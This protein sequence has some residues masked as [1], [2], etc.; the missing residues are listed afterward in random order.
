M[1]DFSLG[2]DFGTSTTLVA[3][4]GLEPR[5]F[6]IGKEAG[7][8]WLPS[9][10][11]ID[12]S[13]NRLIGEDADRGSIQHQFRSPKSAITKS[14]NQITNARGLEVSADEIILEVL[15]EVRI[16]CQENG[17][18][19]FSSVRLSCPAMWTGDQRRRLIRLVNESGLISDIDNILDEP[20]AASVAWWWSRFSKGLKIQS[21]KRA[22]IFDL[23]GGT[24]DV[25]LVDFFPGRALPEMTILSARGIDIAGDELDKR[26]AEHLINRLADEYNFI[27]ED[28]H[29][30]RVLEVA[31]RLAARECKE[32]LSSVEETIF[33]VDPRIAKV[34]SLT[35]SRVELN[36]VFDPLMKSARDCVEAAL[37]EARLKAGNDASGTTVSKLPIS[38]LGEEIDFVVLAGG[39]SQIPKVA[40]DLQLMMPNAQV[41]FAT[42][43]P[44]TST[45]AIVL[46]VA[47][48]NEAADLNIHRPNFDFVVVYQDREGRVHRSILYAAFTPLYQPDQ[49]MRGDK[50]LGFE[51]N[52]IP[53][54]HPKDGK[55]RVVIETVGGREV[56]L[57]DSK[58]DKT[59][60]LEF[61][62]TTYSGLSGKIYANGNIILRGRVD[63][64]IMLRVPEWPHVKW[65]RSM[66]LSQFEIKVETLSIRSIEKPLDWWHH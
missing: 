49:V 58:T 51:I 62:V 35:V 48:L 43:E 63:D 56:R 60:E 9:V 54:W 8:Y 52:W 23:G 20:I 37:R 13:Q 12:E 39:M 29:D 3:L 10:V 47:N 6:P 50:Y 28:Q 57:R 1:S 19:D 41:E 61:R 34:P 5:V 31:I 46:G 4:P 15:K 33:Q 25:A 2:L 55:C 22:V 66:D 65:R 11:S 18:T 45:S 53:P 30:A 16:R 64:G 44:R 21:K 26:L 38:L 40:E 42:S 7:N 36:D 27:A 24:L 32:L 59:Q 14:V 17:I